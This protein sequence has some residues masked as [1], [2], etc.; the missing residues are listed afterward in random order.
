M[1]TALQ[2][3]TGPFVLRIKVY[4][5]VSDVHVNSTVYLGSVLNLLLC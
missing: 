2:A 3:L 4:A 1:L 5:K